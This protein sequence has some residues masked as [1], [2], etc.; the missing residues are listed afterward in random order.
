MCGRQIL[1]RQ[2][3][4]RA[5]EPGQHLDLGA[6]DVDLAE[7]RLAVGRN[8]L[9][10]RPHLDLDAGVPSHPGKAAVGGHRLDP[11]WRHRRHRGRP[12]GHGQ[13][14]GP[15]LG[16]DGDRD[17]RDAAVTTE[18]EEQDAQAVG[19][20]LDRYHPGA[21]LPPGA[22]PAPH[23]GTEVEGNVARPEEL[24]VEV[25]QTAVPAGLAVIDHE[26][27]GDPPHAGEH[28]MTTGEPL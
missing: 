19:L 6:L 5:A 26:G 23:V 7:I 11:A 27:S 17:D 12:G 24:P 10:E 1:E 20:R 2:A 14:S 28:G 8:E 9:V 22:H 3:P 4:Q 13:P 15:G 21:Q 18:D 16:A 25:H